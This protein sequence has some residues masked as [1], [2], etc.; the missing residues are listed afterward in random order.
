MT[1][2][3]CS[4]RENFL[5]FT[6][7]IIGSENKRENNKTLLPETLNPAGSETVIGNR[8]FCRQNH[9]FQADRFSSLFIK[10]VVLDDRCRSLPTE[11][12]YSIREGSDE[13]TEMHFHFSLNI[14][15]VSADI[16]FSKH[17]LA[18][19]TTPS[20]RICTPPNEQESTRS[21]G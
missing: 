20:A 8:D 15:P 16:C 14:F 12:F 21:W 13:M 4:I 7:L 1:G 5:V 6:G 18:F 10:A 19:V 3:V 11:L 9:N 2:N 17:S